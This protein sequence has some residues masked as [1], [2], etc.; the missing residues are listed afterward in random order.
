MF[1]CMGLARRGWGLGDRP[2]LSSV[3]KRDVFGVR[4]PDC[5]QW[6]RCYISV[7]ALFNCDL[8]HVTTFLNFNVMCKMSIPVVCTL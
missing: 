3:A 7:L 6:D 2:L 1:L 5:K 4:N 8:G